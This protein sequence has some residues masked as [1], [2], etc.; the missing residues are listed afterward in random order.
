MPGPYP[1]QSLA[2]TITPQGITAPQYTDILASLTASAQL[3]FGTDVDLDP[4]TADGQLLAVYALAQKITNDSVVAAYNAYSPASAVGAGLASIVKINN[5]RKNAA[6]NST[7]DLTIVGQAG[8][9]ISGGIVFDQN[10]N[11]WALPSVVTIPFSGVVVATATCQVPGAIAAPPDTVGFGTAGTVDQA[12]NPQ[13]GWQSASNA[14]A[15]APG[16]PVES[17]AQL[18]QRQ[19]LS[20][21][22]PAKTTRA[23]IEAAI[24]AIP[25]VTQVRLFQNSGDAPDGNGIPG[26]TLAAV[27]EG[28]DVNLIAAALAGKSP[29]CGTFGTTSIVILDS[30]GVPDTINFFVLSQVQIYVAVV[31]QPLPGY[32]STTGNL[33]VS[34]ITQAINNSGPGDAV[35]LERLKAP[36]DLSGTAATASSGLSQ[37][38]LDAL[39]ATY[40]IR[41]LQIGP[42]PSILG[43]ADLLIPF[44]QAAVCGTGNVTQTIA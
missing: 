42:G 7:A 40:V 38:A 14:Q 11:Q 39:S 27:V 23:A 20:T 16:A 32:L 33:I 26:H 5:L 19:A 10:N 44:F 21:N 25:G 15:A 31:I 9:I 4:D 29:G 24:R 17:D 1:L 8:V 6:S 43:S 34:A 13:P 37:A 41:S 12:L 28:G 36:A 30:E 18:R 22:L 3:I 35:Y 2:A